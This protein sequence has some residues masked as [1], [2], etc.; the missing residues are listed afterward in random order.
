MKAKQK[1]LKKSKKDHALVVSI[2]TWFGVRRSL[3]NIAN[4]PNDIETVDSQVWSIQTRSI[5][6][7]VPFTND[8]GERGLC[9]HSP[10]H[11]VQWLRQE[12]SQQHALAVQVML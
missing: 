6:D 5:P 11:S 10:A 3:R 12:V 7:P 4:L 9:F 2:A 1:T 8:R